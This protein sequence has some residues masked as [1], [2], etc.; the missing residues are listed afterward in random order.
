[1]LLNKHVCAI[2]VWEGRKRQWPYLHPSLPYLS[3]FIFHLAPFKQVAALF[4]P[5]TA[6]SEVRRTEGEIQETWIKQTEQQ[7]HSLQKCVLQRKANR[8]HL[9]E[10]KLCG[11]SRNVSLWFSFR[12]IDPQHCFCVAADLHLPP[13]ENEISDAASQRQRARRGIFPQRLP[14]ISTFHILSAEEGDLIG[15]CLTTPALPLQMKTLTYKA[16][17][18]PT[19]VASRGT[20][21][22][23]RAFALSWT[24]RWRET[25]YNQFFSL[26]P[27][28]FYFA[29]SLNAV[30]V[31]WLVNTWMLL[32][33]WPHS[34][35]ADS[36]IVTQCRLGCVHVSWHRL[37]LLSTQIH[38]WACDITQHS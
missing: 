30:D 2:F 8:I 38:L 21:V 28:S 34:Q 22:S 35:A 16:K 9:L 13:D 3:S 37:Y 12:L 33:S 7:T 4:P 19:H 10:T 31:L 1:M 15:C 27:V 26:L 20:V 32:G 18:L 24:N 29:L 23:G 5:L 6:V 17:S 14:T 25:D 11:R 36:D